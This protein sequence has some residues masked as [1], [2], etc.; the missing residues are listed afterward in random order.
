MDRRKFSLIKIRLFSIFFYLSTIFTA[1]G[2]LISIPFFIGLIFKETGNIPSLF[3]AFLIPAIACVIIGLLLRK[4]SS[5][6]NISL[7]DSMFLCTFSWV[8][9]TLIGAIPYTVILRISYLDACFEA[10]SGLTTT[11]MTMLSGLDNMPKSI[12]FWRSFSEWI[13]GLGILSMFILL[14]FKGGAAANKI[15]LAESHK[16]VSKKPSPGIFQTAKII[17]I[18]YISLTV[19]HLILLLFF[20]LDLFDALAHSFTSVATGGFSTHDQSIAYF[21]L[22]GKYPMY[23][24]IEISFIVIMLLGGINFFIH[25]R[26]MH[27][28]FKSLWDSSEIKY[29]WLFIFISVSLIFLHRIFSGTI[30]YI[31][32]S[33]ESVHGLNAYLLHL[34]DSAFQVV[35]IMTSS[36]YYTREIHTAY[37]APFAKQIFLILMVIGGSAG[38]TSGGFKVIRTVILMKLVNNRIFK[39]NSTPFT[40]APLVVDNEIV[41]DDEVNRIALIFFAWISLIALGGLITA[42]FSELSPWESFSGMFSAVGNIGPCYIDPDNIISL[43]PVIKITY[44]FGMLAG[45]LEIIP[46]LIIFKKKFFK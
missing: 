2:I 23:H 28:E 10:M 37:F 36:G 33:G 15:F 39:M 26:I 43:H 30:E 17:W 7:K 45:R 3:R 22:S 8:I 29:Y 20:G 21:G 25:F 41:N 34:K 14:G 35:S 38:S 40:R 27:G 16:V 46:V 31:L 24:L 32:Y 44:I 13:G 11:G 1:S 4:F 5:P 42:W 12:L 19:I 18:I 6:E 9:L